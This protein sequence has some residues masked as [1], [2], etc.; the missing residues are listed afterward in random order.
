MQMEDGRLQK[1]K[2]M[3]T[4]TGQKIRKKSK[5]IYFDN[6]LHVYGIDDGSTIFNYLER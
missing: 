4:K 1:I 6:F 3:I 5:K 2:E